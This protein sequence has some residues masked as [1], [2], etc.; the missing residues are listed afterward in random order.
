MIT[1]RQ[2]AKMVKRIHPACYR[3]KIGDVQIRLSRHPQPY[4]FY[5]VEI[6]SVGAGK[7]E[8][9][10]GYTASSAFKKLAEM[11]NT[12]LDK[13]SWPVTLYQ[14]IQEAME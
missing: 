4:S 7:A 11:L 1:P 2:A 14:L 8:A 10:A 5:L 3:G 12:P 13:W 6:W 9:Y